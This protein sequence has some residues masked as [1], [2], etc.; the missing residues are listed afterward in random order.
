MVNGVSESVKTPFPIFPLRFT[1]PALQIY[2]PLNGLPAFCIVS[3]FFGK[4]AQCQNLKLNLALNVYIGYIPRTPPT[5]KTIEIKKIY[6][7]T[8]L[9][10]CKGSI[11]QILYIRIFEQFLRVYRYLKTSKTVFQLNWGI[12]SQHENN[13]III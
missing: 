10:L 5:F 12:Y 9:Q 13:S 2:Y 6:S 7:T 1:L 4:L 8:S 11:F 3:P